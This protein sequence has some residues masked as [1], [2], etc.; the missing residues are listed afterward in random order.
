MRTLN[1]HIAYRVVC[2]L[3]LALM[4]APVRAVPPD[5]AVIEAERSGRFLP[6][7]ERESVKATGTTAGKAAVFDALNVELLSQV[8]VAD[9]PGG[10]AA[11]NDVWGYVSG[12]GREYAIVGLFRGTGFVEVTDPTN[13]V[14]LG[15]VSDAAS[16]WSDIAVYGHYA[17]N[18]NESA[19][20]MQ[21]IDLSQ[22]DS[23]VVTLVGSVEN[24][25][26]TAHNVYANPDSGYVYPCGTNVPQGFG[27]LAY[28]LANPANPQPVGAWDGNYAHDL[29]VVS[30]DTC[31]V[32]ALH[33]RAGQPC[34]IAF[35][36]GG[37]AGLF[38]VDVTDKS[39]ITT[40]AGNLT[41]PNLAYCHQG[42]LSA[43]RKYLFVDDELDDWDPAVTTTTYVFNVE[44]VASPTYVLSYTNGNQAT[45]H[46]LMVRGN[47]IFAANYTSGLRI[48]DYSNIFN[49]QEVGHF[50]TSLLPEG[51]GYDGA[52]GVYSDLPSGIV[53]ISDQQGG[54]FVLDPSGAVGCLTDGQCN[55]QNA[56]TTDTCVGG[57]CSNVPLAIG[58]VCQDTNPCTINETCNAAAQCVGTDVNTL[59]C[60][61]DTVCGSSTCDTQ[62]GVCSCLPCDAVEAPL[63]ESGFVTAKSR[64]LSLTPQSAGDV[65]ALRV[66]LSGLP[67]PFQAFNGTSRW[68]GQPVDMTEL[69]GSTD[70]TLPTSKFAPLSCN[71][72]L[73]DFGAEGTIHVYGDGIVPGGSYSVQSI[74]ASCLN[75]GLEE[76]SSPLTLTTSI[77]GDVVGDCT[78]APCT[79]PNGV[80]DVTFD[81]VA[82][83]DKFQNFGGAVAKAR[84][85]ISPG[86]PN[87]KIDIVD[88]AVAVD[89][90]RGL[91]YP[92][93]GPA[94]CPP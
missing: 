34:E 16:T 4:T 80:V 24:G 11:A 20:G 81:V 49:V 64:F 67:A 37:G 22:I 33:P 14:I 18:V 83:L 31:P 55:D 48:F 13:P 68:V 94:N 79:P 12:S 60:V 69:A 92:Y 32:S 27:F 44:N 56:C 51:P 42:W 25:L 39:N 74:G 45:D 66:T 52:W 50:K 47:Y 76:Y 43:D 5:E 8:P 38:V 91:P 93:G 54:L 57:A 77:W 90:F 40:M 61:D 30:Y 53:L 78:V 71:P 82:L 2:C 73:M 63:G 41:Y 88:V 28:D 9:F 86:L 23:G 29:Y 21:V 10:A 46:N 59:S 85:D 58:T 65:T 62:A 3:V 26:A 70:G 87:G 19:G 7:S 15:V 6:A 89:A 72:V 35:A 17:Y 84:S 1:A 75:D 36:F